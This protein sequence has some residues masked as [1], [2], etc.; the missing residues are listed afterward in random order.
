LSYHKKVISFPKPPK[1]E[2]ADK[3][4]FFDYLE[5][6]KNTINPWYEA[7]S[8][9]AQDVFDSILKQHAKTPLPI[10]W[11]N[12]KMLQGEYKQERIWE[13]RFLADGCQQRILGIFG[14]QRKE[15]IFLIGCS[16]KD[17]VYSPPKCLDMALKRAKDYRK[18]AQVEE[19]PIEESL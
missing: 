3:W 15:A 14:N 19:R 13:W 11:G 17:D 10:H 6:G 7:L 16:H 18:G 2:K 1:P 12:S 4:R 8:E 5:N 9:E